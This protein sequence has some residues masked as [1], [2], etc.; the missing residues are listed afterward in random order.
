MKDIEN[1]MYEFGD[2]MIDLCGCEIQYTMLDISFRVLIDY[3]MY[4]MHCSLYLFLSYILQIMLTL[5]LTTIFIPL[6][7]T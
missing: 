3:H 2:N 7:N 1:I 5:R 6:Q 4:L